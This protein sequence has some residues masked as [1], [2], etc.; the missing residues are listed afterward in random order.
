MAPEVASGKVENVQRAAR[1]LATAA[2]GTRLGGCTRDLQGCQQ[3]LA[4]SS[5]LSAAVHGRVPYGKL[6]QIPVSHSM[7][8]PI[9]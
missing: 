6:T 2:E 1:E 8:R 5:Q 7:N 4:S 3:Y 9:A